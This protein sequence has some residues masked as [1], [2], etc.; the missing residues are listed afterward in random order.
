MDP[1]LLVLY[2]PECLENKYR[3]P[4]DD[5]ILR[6]VRVCH[7]QRSINTKPFRDMT[8][9]DGDMRRGVRFSKSNCF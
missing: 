8:R 4:Y 7:R 2:V 3:A 5:G 9:M 1:R 6:N